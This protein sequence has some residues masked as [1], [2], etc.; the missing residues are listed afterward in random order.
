M[1]ETKELLTYRLADIQKTIQ[2]FEEDGCREDKILETFNEVK[3]L[4][5]AQYEK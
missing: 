4:M 3:Q 1:M 2:D 5:S